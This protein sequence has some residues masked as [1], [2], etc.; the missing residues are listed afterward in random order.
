MVRTACGLC[1]RH[2]GCADGMW[3]VRTATGGCGQHLGGADGMWGVRGVRGGTDGIWVLGEVG[4]RTASPSGLVISSMDQLI[5]KPLKVLPSD[6]GPC[7]A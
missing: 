2:V 1:G 4:V 5:R 6:T 3:V 7:P